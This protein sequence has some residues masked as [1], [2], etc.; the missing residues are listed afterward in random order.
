MKPGSNLPELLP[1][2]DGYLRVDLDG[3]DADSVYRFLTEVVVP[4]PIAW[5]TS[6]DA[7]G[8]VNV[9]PF[10]CFTFLTSKPPLVGISIGSRDG[11][12]KDTLRNIRAR[13]EYVVNV[14]SVEVAAL[15]AASAEAFPAG[16]SEAQALGIP[17]APSRELAVPRI[18]DIGVALECRLHRLVDLEDEQRHCFV[19]G[20]IVSASVRRAIVT[21]A[22]IDSAVWKPLARLGRGQFAATGAPFRPQKRGKDST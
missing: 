18:R 3:A 7:D 17:L 13:G 19:V 5:V 2:S 15:V 9:A 21:P 10:S 12:D 6:T 14:P 11:G 16:V 22:G 4:R 1:E 8:L 20:R